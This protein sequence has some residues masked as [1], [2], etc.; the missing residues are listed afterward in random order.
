MLVKD[1]TYETYVK[2]QRGLTLSTY[3]ANNP[4]SNGLSLRIEPIDYE[5]YVTRNLGTLFLAQIPVATTAPEP[6]APPPPPPPGNTIDIGVNPDGS[7]DPALTY[8]FYNSFTYYTCQ[9]T[10]GK[11]TAGPLLTP[12]Q[13]STSGFTGFNLYGSFASITFTSASP[14]NPTTKYP[15]TEQ[16]S[17]LMITLDNLGSGCL[18]KFFESDNT[19]SPQNSFASTESLISLGFQP[20]TSYVT[21]T[22]VTVININQNPTGSTNP[23]TVYSFYN[24]TPITRQVTF[25]PGSVPSQTLAADEASDAVTG[26]TAYNTV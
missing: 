25:T 19:K 12:G 1:W 14:P 23:A 2:K 10:L 5:T 7:L 15:R 26:I 13:T 16:S 21:I 4:T 17:S 11:N 24:L 8:N 18:F 9:V 3:R 6:P 20:R 22:L